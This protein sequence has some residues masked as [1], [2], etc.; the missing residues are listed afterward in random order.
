MASRGAVQTKA[1]AALKAGRRL[2]VVG[3]AVV[4]LI[5]VVALAK[6]P[7][8][9]PIPIPFG[10]LSVIPPETA[11]YATD[12]PVPQGNLSATRSAVG[13]AITA[14]NVSRLKVAWTF[15]LPATGAWGSVTANPIVLGNT[16]YIQ[17]M[18]SNVFAVD[19]ITGVLLWKAEYSIASTGPNGVA[20]G[21]GM[22]YAT[23]GDTGEV[24]ALEAVTGKAV[25]RKQIGHP[26]GEGVDMAP[27]VY[28][29]LVYVSTVPGTTGLEQFYRA[30]DRGILYALDA[31]TGEVV[32]YFDTTN[33]GLGASRIAGGGGLWYPP[34]FDSAGN[35]YFGTGNPGP[36][37]LTP[38]CPN[39]SCRPGPNLYTNSMVSLDGK[40]GAVR[41]YYQDAPHDLLGLDFQHTPI[42]VDGM[43]IGSGKTGNVV[44]VNSNTG[45]VLWKRPVGKH[46]NDHVTE[47]PS[48]GLEV[49]P[50][51][52]GGIESPIA[53]ANGTVFATY[54]DLPQYQ[55]AT[56]ASPEN[57]NF[58][59]ATGGI[60]AIDA[61]DGSVKWVAK[62]PTLV[63]GGATV[64][65][66]VVFT[67]GLD[68]FLRAFDTETGTELWAYEAQSGF[69]APPAIAG[70]MVFVGA[71][72]VKLGSD[73]PASVS[74][75]IA[76]RLG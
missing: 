69:N 72:F 14:E 43:A 34:S 44:A 74:K 61:S 4:V 51:D 11:Q 76:F 63:V 70:D 10:A 68:G 35:L 22:V 33:G 18:Q 54:L 73:G 67:S 56:G 39:G 6:R 3:L 49:Y 31:Q 12:W 13:S 1:A 48:G 62:I 28:G 57:A 66:D 24:V 27:I 71:G 55:T 25:W 75:L 29:G 37:P 41:W 7:A 60:V 32:W 59:S 65:N 19:R 21:Y 38:D 50:G 20:V 52:Y 58:A 47:L 9:V 53:Y 45:K 64:A 40:T 16:V 36:Y 23:L 46:Q 8:V 15:D 17:D 5:E 42:L 2:L 30:G 26:P